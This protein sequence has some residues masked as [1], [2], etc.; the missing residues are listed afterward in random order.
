MSF[1]KKYQ[2]SRK[3]TTYLI[4]I[5]FFLINWFSYAVYIRF[6][7]SKTGRLRLTSA[8]K[9][10]LPKLPEKVIIEAF[11]SNKVPDAYLQQVKQTRDF[12]REYSDASKGKVKLV[13]LDPD[14]DESSKERANLLKVP[15]SQIGVQGEGD[16]QV[17][18]IYLAVV[19]S[20]S[21]QVEIIQN[22]VDTRAL[23]YELTSK[24]FRMSHP[25]ERNIAVIGKGDGFSTLNKEN[26]YQSLE[27]LNSVVSSFYGEIKQVDA[28][29]QEIP[30][31]VTTIF[32]VGPTDLTDIEKFRLDQFIMRGGNLIVAI[33]GLQVDLNSG[34]AAPVSQSVL[35]FISHYGISID[36]NMV[37]EPKNFI[38]IRRPMPG[39][40]FAVQ[41]ISY[42]V[43]LVAKN[44]TLNAD[45][46][47]SKG[48]PGLFF[49][50]TSSIK[51]DSTKL[52]KDSTVDA[53]D[54][55]LGIFVLAS[56][57]SMASNVTDNVM[58]SPQF[59]DINQQSIDVK[60]R[61]IHNLITYSKAKYLS[62]FKD[63]TESKDGTL[64]K[65][66]LKNKITQ[67]EKVSKMLVIG[68]PYF[69]S[70]VSLQQAEQYNLTNANLILNTLDSMNGLDELVNSRSKNVAD[71]MLPSLKPWEIRTWTMINFLI[72]LFAIVIYAFIHLLRRKKMAGVKYELS[73]I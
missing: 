58:I 37:L 28:N 73:N 12:L 5:L 9:E 18:Q 71:P 46:L 40:P 15:Q 65:D 60:S 35:D 42:P 14:N 32:L 36:K 52:L 72:P 49:P 63:I 69:L 26:P 2:S 53:K 23:E 6:D 10:I 33:S 20:Y 8:T 50:W 11:F 44:D 47:I 19:L 16:L 70:N 67:S 64:S 21:D 7:L 43:W 29:Q 39:N 31:D 1:L 54:T 3:V 38:P 66:M 48:L 24:I 25:G 4:L 57:T 45:N 51:I 59:L 27:G 30:S 34:R 41:T 17:K 22:V 62:F 55:S 13:F 56:T 68:T 61:K